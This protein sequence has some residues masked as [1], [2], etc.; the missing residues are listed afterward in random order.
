[1]KNTTSIFAIFISNMV[2]ECTDVT[3]MEK[4][5]DPYDEAIRQS[6][7]EQN[8]E[9]REILEATE[10]SLLLHNLGDFQ[11]QELMMAM[12]ESQKS[13][14]EQEELEKALALSLKD[15]TVPIKDS[16]DG[17]LE[18]TVDFSKALNDNNEND[19]NNATEEKRM[20]IHEAIKAV[21]HEI[22][23]RVPEYQDLLKQ[24][25]SLEQSQ[26]KY[27]EVNQLELYNKLLTDA[28]KS[29]AF[30]YEAYDI[31]NSLNNIDY[32]SIV[33][34]IVPSLTNNAVKRLLEELG[35]Y[36]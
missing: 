14:R 23:N 2:L 21:S 12:I 5:D 17:C 26:D 35:Y 15:N 4:V 19:I 32:T 33:K 6:L 20:K 36:I 16:I 3:A 7:L 25:H 9:E 34:N 30:L 13:F 18:K 27:E 29:K 22:F 11:D 31:Q 10:Q 28:E 8:M 1:M 24:I